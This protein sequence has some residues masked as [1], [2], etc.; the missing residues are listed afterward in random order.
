MDQPTSRRDA[1]RR[2]GVAPADTRVI[3]GSFTSSWYDAGDGSALFA[4]SSS[5]SACDEH[6]RDAEQ[7]DREKNADF[8][9]S[10]DEVG[11]KQGYID[12]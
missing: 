5:A 7:A 11:A 6:G 12:V 9:H 1:A 3:S 4:E 10:D 2:S 8:I